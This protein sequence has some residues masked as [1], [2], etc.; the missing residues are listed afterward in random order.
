MAK[1]DGKPADTQ[2]HAERSGEGFDGS[3]R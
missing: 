3:Q 2:M 1:G